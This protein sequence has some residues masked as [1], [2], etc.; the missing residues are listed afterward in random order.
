MQ[1]RNDPSGFFA[2][3]TGAPYGDD[4]G[5]IAPASNNSSIYFLMS[6]YS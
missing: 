2:N 3:R 1:K 6:N 4:K 5:L